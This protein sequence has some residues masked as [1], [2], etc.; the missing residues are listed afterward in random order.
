SSDGSTERRAGES[1]RT[2]RIP[3]NI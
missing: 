1:F 3:T 2:V